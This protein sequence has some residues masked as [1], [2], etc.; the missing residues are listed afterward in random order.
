MAED[1]YLIWSFEHSAWWRPFSWGYTKEATLAGRYS[2]D[3]ARAIVTRANL[4]RPPEDPFEVLVPS[5]ELREFYEP[6]FE[7]EF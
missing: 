7:N 1:R 2:L 6:F 3:E 4:F 5:D